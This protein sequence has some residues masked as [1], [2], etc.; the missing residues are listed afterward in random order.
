MSVKR[1]FHEFRAPSEAAAEERARSVV[2]SAY[3]DRIPRASRRSRWRLAIAP[4]LMLL[5]GALTLSPAG[6][7]VRRWI[8]RELGVRHPAAALFSLPAPGRVLVSGPGGTWIVAGDGSKRRLGTWRQA[9]WSPHGLFVGVV[10]TD[11]LAAVDPQGAPRWTIARP[12]V[13]D[14]RWYPPTGYRIAYLSGTDLRIVAGDGVGD[15]RLAAGAASVAPAWRPAHP[16]QLAYMTG[17]G[18]LVVRDADTARLIWTA[19]VANAL[20]LTWSA[21][22]QHLL[23]LARKRARIYSQTGRLLTTISMPPGA[24]IVD[25]A[26]SPGGRTVALVRGGDADDVV[27]ANLASSNHPLRRVL[28]GFGLRQLTWSPDG[29]W[30][31]VSWPGADQ[32]VFIRVAGRPRIEAVSRIAEQLT[33]GRSPHGFPAL[34]GWCCTGQGAAG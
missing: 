1:A 30:L 32:W 6:A 12:A 33:P 24:T 31:L 5:A 28:S 27:L 18:R 7:S 4:A 14:P 26:L 34:D 22:G 9:S 17:R 21:N 19:G 23:V 8:S 29:R 25:G 15:H 11:E 16:Y 10:G 3:L 2:R 20:T 13:S